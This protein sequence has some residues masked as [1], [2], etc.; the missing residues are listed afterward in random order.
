MDLVLINPGGRRLTYQKLA[1][2]LAGIEP[3]LWIGLLASFAR[4]RKISVAVVDADAEGLDPDQTAGRVAEI[5]P[6]LAVVVV[7]GA[8]PSAS[9]QK[10]T[11]A[12][13][14]C[15]ALA[16]AAPTVKRALAGLH[17]SAL[18]E[19][20]LREEDV[21]F[22][23]EG[24]GPYTI[25]ALVAALKA[26]AGRP[27]GAGGDGLDRVPGLWYRR[28]DEIA[29]T[30][31]APLVADL[32]ADLPGVAWD[33]LPM[34]R[35]RAHNWHCFDD[36]DRRSPYAVIY[37]SLGCPF[38]CSFCCINALFGAPG[39]R[40]R[41]PESVLAEIDLLVE[42][43]GVRH[44]KVIDELFVLKRGRV[45]RICDMLIERGHDLNFW[46]YARVDTVEPG[47]LAKMKRA[48]FHWLA[49]GFESASQRVRDGVGKRS[50]D[51]RTNEAIAW[52]RQAGIHIIANFI[53]GLPDDDLDTMAETLAMAKDHNF[54]FVNF[55][56]AMAYPGSRLYEQASARGWALPESWHQYAQFG[57]ESLPLP[58][59]H[60]S[61][62]D[63][64]R[65][66]DR[67][68][69]DYFSDP[70]YQRMIRE[71]FGEEALAHVRRML[72]H[73]M[74]RKFAPPLGKDA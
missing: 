21:D 7:F 47:L 45:E 13:A 62:A 49:Y 36:I 24:E 38:T 35:Y 26:S 44:I 5:D 52:T 11:V 9:T 30:D 43:Y 70:R 69:V 71:T 50:S 37:T 22:V 29:H 25:E 12:G 27:F 58:T 31:R 66:R 20:T 57:T 61:A 8:N 64:L 32:D 14:I 23:I 1:S 46:V 19:R 72:E 15:S 60:L 48:G 73:T 3:P 28:G 18:P 4:A 33:L 51:G 34:D 54:E 39:I 68:F 67:A 10:M 63:V 59:K 42:R 41:S 65:F 74:V 40:Y 53:F 56:C 55:Y 2:D 6:L 17:V 16:Q